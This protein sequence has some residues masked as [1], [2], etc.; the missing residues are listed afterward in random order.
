MARVGPL[1]LGTVLMLVSLSK[2][3]DTL[4]RDGQVQYLLPAGF[5]K[6]GLQLW[7]SAGQVTQTDGQITLIRDISDNANDASRSA[8]STAPAAYPT[9]VRDA[10][11]GSRCCTFLAPTLRLASN[12]SPASALLSGL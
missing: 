11:S 6:A 5:P 2:A 8:D 7:L 4:P 1:I 3:Q 9:L 12:A 10:A